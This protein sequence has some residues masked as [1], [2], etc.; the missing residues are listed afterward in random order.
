MA[1]SSSPP[2]RSP[3]QRSFSQNGIDERGDYKAVPLKEEDVVE[4]RKTAP[5]EASSSPTSYCISSILM[6]VVNKVNDQTGVGQGL[7]C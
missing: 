7:H 2:S 1:S 3:V 6:T 5:H 4:A